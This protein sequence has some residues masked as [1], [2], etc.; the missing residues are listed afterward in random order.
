MYTNR[1]TSLL[2]AGLLL[3]A[4][5]D[6]TSDQA[7]TTSGDPRAMQ[8]AAIWRADLDSLASR[9]EQ[10]DSALAAMSSPASIAQAR[11]VFVDARRAFKHAEL[12]LEYYA[13]T[14]TREM[15]GPALPEVEE[16]DGPEAVFAPTG[17]QV[18]E[19]GLFG[20]EP[21]AERDALVQETRT[22]RQILARVQTLMRTQVVTDDRVWD[23]IK[24]EIARIVSLGITGFDSPV[25]GL[26]LAEADDALEGV[27]RSL[28]PYRTSASAWGTLDS[29]LTDARVMLRTTTDRESFD[30][31]TFIVDHANPLARAVRAVRT[32]LGIGTPI[33]RRAFRM[34]AVTLF[35]SAAFDLLAFAPLDAKMATAAQVEL[36]RRLFHD[37]RLSGDDRRACSTCHLPEKAFTD[38]LKV[39][40]SRGGAPLARN[41]P[42]VIN[43]GLQ[44]GV[45][46]DLRTTYLED[47]V[48]DVVE[49]VDEMHGSLD[50]IAL[51]LG[52]DSSLAA[53]F[54]MAF[55]DEPAR[56]DTMVSAARIRT[57][58]AAYQRSLTRLDSPVDQALRGN[59]AVLNDSAR[60]GFNVFV[61]KGKCATCHFLPLTNGTVPPFY[62]KS[63]VE[64]LGTPVQA[65]TRRATVDPDVG[66][67]RL[68]RAAPHKYA[69]R[70]PSIRNVALTAPYMHNGVYQTLEQVVDFYNR[71]GGAGIGITLDNQTL[72]PDPLNLSATE[73]RA[74]V[75]F[76]RA[77]TDT[78]GTQRR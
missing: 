47:Q 18:I 39:N 65:V 48:T 23:A 37:T 21:L 63:D 67:Y 46:S 70:T 53:Q 6:S 43:S 60:I 61:G 56:G 12:G 42:T 54:R 35:D 44:L 66:R 5:A 19:E 33:E 9:V 20:D 69:F 73:Q 16:N 78:A 10:L 2:F 30:H 58:L 41:T 28:T 36:G 72:P 25:A 29:A 27:A 32:S 57:A 64:V 71:G 38:G 34:D 75:V 77:L 62:Q 76:M 40:R 17:F 24:L 3:T 59:V 68:S 52:R 22:L 45:F 51:S 7:T 31:F 8:V 13:A 26:S 14:S 49:N 15:N 50:A 55:F 4:C 11:A 74:L 1:V